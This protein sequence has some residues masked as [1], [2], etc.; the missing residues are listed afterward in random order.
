MPYTS[1]DDGC[2]ELLIQVDWMIALI[3]SSLAFGL[4]FFLIFV[5]YLKKGQFEDDEDVK[6]QI[7]RDEENEQ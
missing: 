7:F 2:D 3:V 6:Y 1:G 5:F 4:G